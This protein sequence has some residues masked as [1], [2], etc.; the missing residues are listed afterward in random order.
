[1]LID[2]IL[3]IIC[4]IVLYELVKNLI[5]TVIREELEKFRE[6]RDRDG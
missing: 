1:M 3:A 2:H 4:G 6:E 5:R